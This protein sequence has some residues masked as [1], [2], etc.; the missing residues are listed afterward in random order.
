MALP[1]YIGFLLNCFF[2]IA[3]MFREWQARQVIGVLLQRL[4][5]TTS[6]GTTGG[7]SPLPYEKRIG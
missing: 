3:M 5:K 4:A 6:I 1:L 2:I 7:A